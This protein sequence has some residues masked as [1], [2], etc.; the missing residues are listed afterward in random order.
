[1]TAPDRPLR[2]VIVEDEP[3]NYRRLSEALATFP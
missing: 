2:A 1:M 3:L